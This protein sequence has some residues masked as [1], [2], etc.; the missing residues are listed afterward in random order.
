MTD[1]KGEV[2]RKTVIARGLI[3]PLTSINR[4]QTE[5]QQGNS[6]LN[7]TLDQMDL[8]AISRAFHPKAAECTYFSRVRGTF[9]SVDH[10][11]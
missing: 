2:D 5:K 11:L 6:S 9:S 4:S 8:T 7:D 10:M 1:I 3:T